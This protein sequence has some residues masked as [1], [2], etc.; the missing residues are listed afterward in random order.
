MRDKRFIAVHRG[1]QLTKDNQKKLIGWAISC[2]EHVLPMFGD[3]VDKQLTHAIVV[4]KEWEKGKCT[5]GE[6]IKSAREVHALAKK[7]TNPVSIAIAR[8]IGHAVATAHMADH[9]LGGAL[10]ALKAV[11]LMGKSLDAERAW[12]LHELKKL[13]PEIVDLVLVTMKVKE[14]GLKI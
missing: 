1:G 4:A 7:L 13:P 10:Y 5:T 3:T 2:S 6:A 8:S 14:K 9:S 12:Q 11:K